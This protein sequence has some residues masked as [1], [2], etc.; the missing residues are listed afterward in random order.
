MNTNPGQPDR[1]ST[2]RTLDATFHPGTGVETITQ[3]GNLTYVDNDRKA[4]ADR[5]RYTTADQMLQQLE[6]L[7]TN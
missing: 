2:S 3:Q 5:G 6:Q 7:P 1:V 4:W